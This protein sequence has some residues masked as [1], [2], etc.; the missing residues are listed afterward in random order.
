MILPENFVQNI[1]IN[2]LYIYIYWDLFRAVW[3]KNQ[4]TVLL[5]KFR[6]F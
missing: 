2:A 4:Y 1:L 6:G 5:N 3:T